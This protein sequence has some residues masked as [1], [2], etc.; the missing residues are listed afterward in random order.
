MQ[1]LNY[2]ILKRAGLNVK[3]K[4]GL[5]PLHYAAK[6]DNEYSAKRLLKEFNIRIDVN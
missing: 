5:T 6:Y 4:D 1:T 2:L 3:D